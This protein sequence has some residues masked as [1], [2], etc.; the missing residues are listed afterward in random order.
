MQYLAMRF[1]VFKLEELYSDLEKYDI[2]ADLRGFA[3]K[4]RS[5]K[6]HKFMRALTYIGHIFDSEVYYLNPAPWSKPSIDLVKIVGEDDVNQMVRAHAEQGTK[7][8]L[9]YLVSRYEDQD[10]DVS[11]GSSWE[12]LLL[13]VSHQLTL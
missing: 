6:F 10:P 4:G 13:G 7:I 11:I 9:L 1:K 5:V 8:C 2:R 3:I 12:I